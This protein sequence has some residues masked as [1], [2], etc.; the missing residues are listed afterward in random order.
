MERGTSEGRYLFEFDGI[1]AIRS[2]EVNGLKKTHEEFELPE[3]NKGNPHLGRGHFKCEPIKVKHGHA[4]NSTGEEFFQ[5][6]E[7]FIKGD[8]V[9]RRGGRLV[10]LDEDGISPVSIY[11]LFDCVPISFE[12]ETHTAGGKNASYFSFTIRPE[13]WELL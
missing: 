6:M 10:V 5:W 8:S 12:A 11:E 1:T 3:S 4:L 9:E 2:T 13:D 7:L